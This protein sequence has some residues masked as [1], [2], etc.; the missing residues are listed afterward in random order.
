MKTPGA[1]FGILT[2]TK[3]PNS[4]QMRK[5]YLGVSLVVLVNW[6]C[7]L[8]TSRAD[9]VIDWGSNAYVKTNVLQGVTNVIALAAGDQHYLALKADGTVA[10]WGVNSSGQTNV[11]PGLTN[12]ASIAAGSAHSL[13]LRRD[14]TLALW[15]R[16]LPTEVNTVPNDATNIVGLALGPGAQ[17]ALVLR[18]DGTVLDWGGNSAYGLTNIPAMARNV[19]AVAAGSS[20]CLA[21]RAD[22]KVVAWGSGVAAVPAAATNIVAI[23]TGWSGNAALRADGTVLVWGNAAT[24]TSGFTN[25]VEVACPFSAFGGNCA[26]LA[27]RSDGTLAVNPGIAPTVATNVAAVGAGGYDG[28]ALIGSGPPIFAGMPINRTVAGGSTAYLR[29]NPVGALPL[30]FQWNCNG[31][32]IPGATDPVLVLTNVQPNQ[33]GSYYTLTASNTFGMATNGPITLNEVP[34]E[35][36]IQPPNLSTV[37]GAAAT[38]I[39]TNIVGEGPFSYQWECNSTII[40]GATN[41]VL[42]LANVQLNQGGTYSVV[43]GNGYGSVTNTAVLTVRPFVF[44]TRSPNLLMTTNGLRLQLDSVYATNSVVLFA[45]TNLA[46]WLPVLTNPP[47]T[48]SVLFLDSAATNLPRRFYRAN[49]R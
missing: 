31:T 48:G 29:M 47:A 28:I 12:V 22:G 6:L 23:A 15:G 46:S 2:I 43:V 13:A 39:V 41:S 3:R 42:P 18:S 17:H 10:T 34:L 16:I 24:P 30:F 4:S 8:A 38:F 32:N 26:V 1:L 19:V 49:E 40:D 37:V 25:V 11:P 7:S 45:S 27:A 36:S 5:T 33:A 44:N 14:G 9:P 21:L 35:F 20:Y